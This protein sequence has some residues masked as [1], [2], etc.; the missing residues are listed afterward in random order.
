MK[1]IL[2]C[3]LASTSISS[4]ANCD[5]AIT[6]NMFNQRS[7]L[8]KEIVRSKGYQIVYSSTTDFTLEISG[9]SGMYQEGTCVVVEAQLTN[10]KTNKITH[11][12]KNSSCGIFIGSHWKRRIKKVLAD[13]PVCAK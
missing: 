2:L 7:D 3:M 4:F 1:K 10:N 9:D 8:V 13:L 11:K 5:I 6:G 12:E